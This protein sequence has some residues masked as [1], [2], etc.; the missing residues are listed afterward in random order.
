MKSNWNYFIP[1]S[2]FVIFASLVLSGCGLEQ[3][4]AN[5]Q[6]G[7]INILRAQLE[8]PKLPLEFVETTFDSNSPSGSLQVEVYQDT[9]GRK[10]FVD[11]ISNHVVEMDARALL[12]KI[13]PLA[14]VLSENQV[15]AKAQKLIAA[16][17]P[18]FETLQT[19]WV[20][21]EGGKIDNYFFTWYGE[22][23]TGSSNLPRAQIA[24]H[25]TGLLF[26][27]YNTLM[28]DR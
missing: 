8:L 22:S 5:P 24:L 3:P 9:A 21:E 10:Y 6:I 2:F 23:A 4:P 15:R 18:G 11:P 28:L 17:I 14:S 12:E 27:Y 20:Y 7:A 16:A 19:N 25:R 13:S 26:A 1:V